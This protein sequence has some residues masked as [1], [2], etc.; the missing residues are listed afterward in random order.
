[1]LLR[2]SLSEVSNIYTLPFTRAVWIAIIALTMVLTLALVLSERMEKLDELSDKETVEWG[3]VV[4]NTMAIVCQQGN[5][6]S[7]VIFNDVHMSLRPQG[8]NV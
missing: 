2:P 4:M 5:F 1:M 6:Q 3:E 8:A 7:L